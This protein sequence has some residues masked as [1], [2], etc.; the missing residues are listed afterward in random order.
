M[1]LEDTCRD[2]L[3]QRG[4]VGLENVNEREGQLKAS[5]KLLPLAMA[6]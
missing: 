6:S 5:L 3:W 4:W 1:L 2:C